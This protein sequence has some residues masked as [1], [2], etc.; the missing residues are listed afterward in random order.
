MLRVG[1]A[2]VDITPGPGLHMSG[3]G[4]A[5]EAE[6]VNWPLFARALLLDD[7]AERAALISLDL[8]WLTY[9]TVL[10]YRRALAPVLGLPPGNIMIACSH[11]HRG[12][13]TSAL[14]AD[15]EADFDY[16]DL[17]RSRL[18]DAARDA[19]ATLRPARLKVGRTQTPGWTWSRRPI[20]S[21]GHVGTHGPRYGADYL[22]MEGPEDNEVI[23]LAALDEGGHVVGGLV[24][25]ACHTTV[26]G[27]VPEY[28]ADFAGPLTQEMR[29]RTG[30]VFAF[31]QGACGNLSNISGREGHPR[32]TGGDYAR[33]M[34]EALAGSALAALERGED[35]EDGQLHVESKLLSIPQR[36]PTLDQI[37]LARWYL[38]KAP[39]DVD[40]RE[41]TRRIY[42]H[43]YTFYGN[44]PNIQEWF[45]RETI[46]MYE[47]QRRLMRREVREELE[48]QAISLGDSLAFVGYPAEYFTEFG[49]ETKAK[50][51]FKHTL[52]AELANGWVGYVPTEAAFAH[53][54]YECR[55]TYSSRLVP[56]AGSLMCR[57]GVGLLRM[58]SAL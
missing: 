47:Y 13:F 54:G 20:Y 18:L 38:E 29:S 41:F 6:G 25:F 36:R 45:C 34:G 12:P 56:Q 10:E 44:S 3:M 16:L 33:A 52:V 53:G 58:L 43:D 51:P 31:L 35:L 48:I 30:G 40:Q 46:A 27:H 17:L 1:L 4:E 7:G 5:P 9:P 2:E 49:L 57:T 11:T 23:A 26:M 39:P 37:E 28:S 8:L 15:F 22:G 24:N 14:F 21:G 50:S 32:E 19:M 55:F 42:G